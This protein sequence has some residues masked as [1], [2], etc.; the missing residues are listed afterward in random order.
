MEEL[1]KSSEPKGAFSTLEIS[2]QQL[3]SSREELESLLT[4]IKP[5]TD[6]NNHGFEHPF[7][8]MLSMQQWIETVSR[9]MNGV[10]LPKSKR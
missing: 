5:T 9:C 2:I 3:Q 8:G 1:N 7:F 6:F 4:S 10:I